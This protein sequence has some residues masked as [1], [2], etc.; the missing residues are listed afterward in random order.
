[1]KILTRFTVLGSFA[2]VGVGVAV[3]LGVST[4]P[5]ASDTEMPTPGPAL[6]QA[7]SSEPAKTKPSEPMPVQR[8]PFVLEE[9]QDG[10]IAA[11]PPAPLPALINPARTQQFPS[12]LDKSRLEQVFEQVRQQMT[13]GPALSAAPVPPVPAPPAPVPPVAAPIPPPPAASTPA[14]QLH[15]GRR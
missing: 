4:A 2:A 9:I 14:R 3:C 13:S 12:D 1:M 6:V 15:P 7:A 10:R 11:A 5:T 8:N